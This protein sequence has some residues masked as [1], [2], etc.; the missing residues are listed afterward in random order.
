MSNK[1]RTVRSIFA[2]LSFLCAMMFLGVGGTLEWN[3]LSLA[4]GMLRMG[5]YG[6]WAYIFACKAGLFEW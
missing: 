6:F 1:V 3:G 5:F 2:A 4:T